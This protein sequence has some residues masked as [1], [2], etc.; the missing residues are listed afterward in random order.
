MLINSSRVLW[1]INRTGIVESEVWKRCECVR[2]REPWLEC[3]ASAVL[4]CL[5][6][7]TCR[8]GA[9]QPHGAGLMAPVK[10]PVTAA[11]PAPGEDGRW[12]VPAST[13]RTFVRASSFSCTQALGLRLSSSRRSLMLFV[14]LLAGW[15]S[16]VSCRRLLWGVTGRAGVRYVIK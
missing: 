12:Q 3:R 10:R 8:A 5:R 15:R 16:R 4:L 1:A 2:G 11:H 6:A 14:S 13:G 7:G 9:T